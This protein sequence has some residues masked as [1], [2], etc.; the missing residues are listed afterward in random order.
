MS[1][2]GVSNEFKS[3]TKELVKVT[4]TKHK[5]NT[6]LS[7]VC[8]QTNKSEITTILSSEQNYPLPNF[9]RNIQGVVT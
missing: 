3:K 9:E 2:I 8:L 5:N 6:V 1:S 7:S 4:T